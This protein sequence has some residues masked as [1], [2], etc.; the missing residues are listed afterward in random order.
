MII[1][2]LSGLWRR[3]GRTLGTLFGIAFG[4][5][6][7]IALTA[8][9]TGFKEA[10][11]L[12]LA[13]IGADI[14]LTRPVTSTD[15]A[16]QTTR[17]VRQPFGLAPLDLNEVEE[18]RSI[19]GVDFVSEGIYLW[20]FGADSYQTILGLEAAAAEA[21]PAR[22]RN[23]VVSGRFFEPGERGVLVV[24]RHYAAFF[25]LEPGDSVD[26]G[27]ASFQVVGIVEVPGGNQAAEANFYMP[28]ADAQALSGLNERQV[29][30]VYI[31]V[32]QAAD[33]EAIVAESEQRLGRLTALTEQSIVQVMGGI[34]RVTDRFAFLIAVV[35]LLGGL[36]LAFLSMSSSV[37]ARVKE[38]GVMKAVGWQAGQIERVILAEGALVSLIGAL[39]GSVLGW[40]AIIALSQVPIELGQPGMETTPNLEGSNSISTIFLP[41]SITTEAALLALI[42]TMIGGTLAGWLVARRAARQK[43][44]E[45]LRST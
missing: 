7:F 26:I 36:F 6:L 41:A 20:N 13:G 14:L 1:Y 12:P 23:W 15:A 18:L 38:I 4:M 24:D 29:N 28:L 9:Q 34:A 30:Q 5:A 10:A 33:I 43:P 27:Q 2:V 44:V 37:T 39:L 35:A 19:P 40:L 3:P 42:V 8:A 21:G 17:G 25:Q 22:V 45:A 16:S 32:G 11:R 31:R